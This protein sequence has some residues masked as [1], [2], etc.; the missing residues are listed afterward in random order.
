MIIQKLD[1]KIIAY[2]LVGLTILVGVIHVWQPITI[3]PS[4]S[5][6]RFNAS[7]LLIFF[8]CLIPFGYRFARV[9]LGWIFLLFTSINLL[10]FL[11]YIREINGETLGGGFLTIILGVLGYLL[12]RS[13]SIRI[14]EENRQKQQLVKS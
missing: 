9:G 10:I 3:S 5:S 7:L 8:A 14:F 4:D 2:L 11:T 12:L 6:E 13:P 1:R